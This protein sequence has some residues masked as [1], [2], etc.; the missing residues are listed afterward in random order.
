MQGPTLT[1]RVHSYSLMR[2]VIGTLQRPRQPASMWKASPLVV[3]NNFNNNQ[4]ELKLATVLI[5]NL[6]PAINV[7]KA[8]LASCQVRALAL[9][10]SA[11]FSAPAR[12][13]SLGASALLA[14]C[15]Q[16]RQPSH[17]W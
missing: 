8:K 12:A 7:Q 5:Q 11:I 9:A 15:C 2:D 17:P 4:N 13:L 6:F 10:R 14:H 3:M 1:M 16:G